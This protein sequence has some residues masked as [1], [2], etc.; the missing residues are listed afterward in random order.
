MSDLKLLPLT[1]EE[2]EAKVNAFRHYTDEVHAYVHVMYTM[3]MYMII[4]LY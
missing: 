3:F 1:A 4:A 2:V